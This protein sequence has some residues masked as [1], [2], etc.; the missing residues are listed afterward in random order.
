MP[1]CL[2]ELDA[3][4]LKFPVII[5][6]AAINRPFGRRIL[7]LDDERVF[8][9]GVFYCRDAFEGLETI[10]QL[11]D[12]TAKEALTAKIRDEAKTNRERETEKA[13][14]TVSSPVSTERSET[15]I[16]VSIPKPPFWGP[17]VLTDI[18]L[19]AVY[20]C[21]DRISL[22]KMSW[23]FRGI[24]DPE[25]WA[26]LVKEELE[27]RL[28]RS[29]NEAREEGF[30]KLDAVYGYWPAQS[31]GNQVIVFDPDDQEKEVARFLFPRQSAQHRLC[32]ADYLR[33][34]QSGEM[35]VVALQ[36]TT[37][38]S[39]AGRKSNQLQQSGD[40]DDMLR[41]HGFATQMVEAS[42]EW[43]HREIR[44]E[45]ALES[46]R[47]RR[48]SWGYPAC[49]ELADHQI[50]C[51]IVPV[52]KI[53]VSLTDGYQFMPEHTTAAIVMHHPEARYFSIY[54]QHVGAE[55]AELAA[56]MVPVV[57]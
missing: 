11:I 52:Q 16:D 39:E 51:S 48:Y 54:A 8:E 20:P 37:A 38:G 24:R 1:L 50:F 29:M 21:I 32:M 49:P 6:G 10:D 12:P 2:Q 31:E 34:K 41:V 40:Y 5:G 46:D 44:K 43:L 57:G 3:R 26:K 35:D 28:E 4:G 27:P 55:E 18:A 7:Y 15:R 17:K 33:P 56:N 53:G 36:I 19:D 42:A 45:L 23:Q 9:P 47:G 30:V 13:K 25:K 14:N 22:F